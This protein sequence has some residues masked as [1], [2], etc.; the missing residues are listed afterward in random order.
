ML[1]KIVLSEFKLLSEKKTFEVNRW[2]ILT[3]M[4][5]AK[6]ERTV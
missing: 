6:Q 2:Q 1:K 5:F 3:N 4:M